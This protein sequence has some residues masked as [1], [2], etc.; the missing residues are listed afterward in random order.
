MPLMPTYTCRH[1]NNPYR[2]GRGSGY[3][4]F[5]E[6]G[7]RYSRLPRGDGTNRALVQADSA[8]DWC[9]ISTGTNNV[10]PLMEPT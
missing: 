7:C 8:I 1:T 4:L 10:F 5:K 9:P 3:A 2:Q 6:A